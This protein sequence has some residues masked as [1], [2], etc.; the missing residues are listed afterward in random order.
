[1]LTL[2]VGAPANSSPTPKRKTLPTM[3]NGVTTKWQHNQPAQQGF[4]TTNAFDVDTATDVTFSETYWAKLLKSGDTNI[5]KCLKHT[6]LMRWDCKGRRKAT[7][8]TRLTQRKGIKPLNLIGDLHTRSTRDRGGR[9]NTMK[10]K[11][12][13]NLLRGV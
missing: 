7:A 9:A 1:M 2:S 10:P 6:T 13:I 4:E 11:N 12:Q 3:Q 8:D 5:D